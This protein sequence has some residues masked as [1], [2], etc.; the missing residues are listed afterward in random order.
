MSFK[1]ASEFCKEMKTIAIIIMIGGTVLAM[2]FAITIYS[3]KSIIPLI[4]VGILLLGTLI[5]GIGA[6]LEN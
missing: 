2:L 1:G 5:L 6:A 3:G 4:V